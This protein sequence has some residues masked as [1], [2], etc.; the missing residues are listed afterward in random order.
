MRCI[1][2]SCDV[3]YAQVGGML[4]V[5]GGWAGLTSQS[6][7]AHVVERTRQAPP[8]GRSAG[9][10]RGFAPVSTRKGDN[11]A[12]LSVSDLLFYLFWFDELPWF[13]PN[14][15]LSRSLPKET[16]SFITCNTGEGLQYHPSRPAA[17][18]GTGAPKLK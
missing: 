11:V 12:S 1:D 15:H 5:P 14:P 7:V 16:Y 18:S 17:A 13:E 4:L 6:C 10:L 9:M 2:V 3:R 8:H